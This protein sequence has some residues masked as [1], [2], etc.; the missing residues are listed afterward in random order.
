MRNG[1]AAGAFSTPPLPRRP[2]CGA[3]TPP[4]PPPPVPKQV[5][6]NRPK[7]CRAKTPFRGDPKPPAPPSAH[8]GVFQGALKREGTPHHPN[9]SSP[10]PLRAR[11][12]CS[13]SVST[14]RRAAGRAP[15]PPGPLR[16]RGPGRTHSRAHPSYPM[17]CRRPGR[18]RAGRRCR[19]PSAMRATPGAGRPR[20]ASASDPG[21]AAADARAV[22]AGG[23]RAA[24]ASHGSARAHWPC[25]RRPPWAARRAR[26]P[27]LGGRAAAVRSSRPRAARVGRLRPLPAPGRPS[28]R[29]RARARAGLRRPPALP[30]TAQRAVSALSAVPGGR[31]CVPCGSICRAPPPFGRTGP[32]CACFAPPASRVT[33]GIRAFLGPTCLRGRRRAPVWRY[34]LGSVL[35]AL[36]A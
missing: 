30:T 13:C 32:G 18:G 21:P 35:P 27:W 26:A 14:A 23:A 34:R 7:P 9:A 24:G 16:Q 33:P 22:P 20:G 25:R 12:R 10:A 28:E 17:P 11:A 3:F 5:S 6:L 1:S 8:G 29:A 31:I 19:A 2:F 36:R 4:N 15:S